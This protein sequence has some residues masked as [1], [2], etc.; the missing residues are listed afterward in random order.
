ME[1]GSILFLKAI[2]RLLGLIILVL[3]I[4]WLPWLAELSAQMNP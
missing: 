3:S 4:F 1:H 2:I